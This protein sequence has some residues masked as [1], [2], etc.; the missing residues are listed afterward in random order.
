M[1][2]AFSQKRW[3]FTKDAH[4]AAQQQFYARMFPHGVEFKDTTKT[5]LDLEYAIDCQLSVTLPGDGFRAP[6]GLAVQERFRDP[7]EM[8]WGDVTITEW[9]LVTNE[10]SELHKLGAQMFVYGFYDKPADR[11]VKAAAIDVAFMQYALVHGDIKPVRQRRGDQ[12][13]I[14]LPIIALRSIGA[15][16]FEYPK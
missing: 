13:F 14:G 8:H 4:R 2:T 6:I 7:A 11:I 3:E 1:G 15:V 10:P 16:M 12:S 5:E 9:N